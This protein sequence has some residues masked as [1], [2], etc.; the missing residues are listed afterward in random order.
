MD[1]KE[2]AITYTYF[3]EREK[4]LFEFVKK[5]HEGQTRNYTGE[6]YWVHP[7]EVASHFTPYIGYPYGVAVALCHDLMEEGMTALNLEKGLIAVGYDNF[8]AEIIVDYCEALTPL[9]EDGLSRMER[10]IMEAKRLSMDST[11]CSVKCADIISNCKTIVERDPAFAKTYLR[12]KRNQLLHLN[13]ADTDIYLT[14]CQVVQNALDSLKSLEDEKQPLSYQINIISVFNEK[15][16]I[17]IKSTLS[18][19]DI[20]EIIECNPHLDLEGIANLIKNSDNVFEF[21]DVS[22]V[23]F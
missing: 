3:T 19:K 4:K 15:R 17:I 21:Y 7:L 10:A 2:R 22:A 11:L 23:N 16:L 1:F 8:E 9:K 20:Y 12:E 5:G 6:P 14:A 13:N 18:S